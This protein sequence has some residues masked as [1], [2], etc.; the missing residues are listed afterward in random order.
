MIYFT[1]H[2]PQT[3]VNKEEQKIL[4]LNP[5]DPQLIKYYVQTCKKIAEKE[6]KSIFSLVRDGKFTTV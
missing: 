6:L 1:E 3:D 2:V 5:K 4:K